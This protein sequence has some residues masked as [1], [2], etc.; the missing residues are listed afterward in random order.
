MDG[1]H[2]DAAPTASRLFDPFIGY[3]KGAPHE[4]GPQVT[5]PKDKPT[6]TMPSYWTTAGF[7]YAFAF[8]AMAIKC[9]A[10]MFD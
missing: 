5:S 1:K 8:L 9:W 10:L 7:W 3:A 2:R 4:V 6:H